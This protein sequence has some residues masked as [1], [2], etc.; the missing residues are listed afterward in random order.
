MKRAT[1]GLVALAVIVV[2]AGFG[3]QQTKSPAPAGSSG[4]GA[5]SMSQPATAEGS[6]DKIAQAL[7]QLSEEDRRLAE[8]QGTCPVSGEQ[9]GSMG[10][11]IKLTVAGQDVFI[12]CEGCKED[13]LKNPDQYLKKSEAPKDGTESDGTSGK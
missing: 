11:P 10:V 6:G 4:A 3:C 5:S 8:A 1:G 2:L 7:A 9:L 13:L 12:C